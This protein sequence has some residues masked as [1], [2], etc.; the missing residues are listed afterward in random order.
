MALATKIGIGV[1]NAV[2]IHVGSDN[3]QNTAIFRESR[4]YGAGSV[5]ATVAAARTRSSTGID[6][7][8]LAAEAAA[9]INEEVKMSTMGR[10]EYVATGEPLRQAFDAEKYALAG[11]II[12]SEQAWAMVSTVFARK[13]KV[14]PNGNVKID[15]PTGMIRKKKQARAELGPKEWLLNYIPRSAHLFLEAEDETRK[16][17]VSELRRITVL[18]VNI[19]VKR[20][21]I[22][23]MIANANPEGVQLLQDS[24]AKVQEAVMDYEGSVNKFLIDDK[25]STVIVVFGL[26]PISHEN[27]ATRGVL[28]SLAVSSLLQDLG[29]DPAVGVASGSAFCGV[30]GHPGGRRE[31]TVLGDIVNLSARLMQRATSKSLGVLC[32]TE[33]KY[34]AGSQLEFKYLKPISVKGKAKKVD[35]FV[36]FQVPEKRKRGLLAKALKVK[37]DRRRKSLEGDWREQVENFAGQRRDSFSEE[38]IARL[39]FEIQ[40]KSPSALTD[41]AFA[42]SAGRPVS[43]S[44]AEPAFDDEAAASMGFAVVSGNRGTLSMRISTRRPPAPPPPPPRLVTEL[45]NT[46]VSP[47]GE[48]LLARVYRGVV[49]DKASYVIEGSIGIGKS[50]AL[51]LL[52]GILVTEPGLWVLTSQGNPFARGQLAKAFGVIAGL[53]NQAI[54]LAHLEAQYKKSVG[55]S[56]VSS[57][58]RVAPAS[59]HE[60][61]RTQMQAGEDDQGEIAAHDRRAYV[62][63]WLMNVKSKASDFAWLLNEDLGVDFYDKYEPDEEGGSDLEEQRL[64]KSKKTE[65]LM[66]VFRGLTAERQVAVLMDDPMYMD[67]DSWGLILNM[68]RKKSELGAKGGSVVLVS[69]PVDEFV[70]IDPV[71]RSMYEDFARIDH[72]IEERVEPLTAEQVHALTLAYLGVKSIP[73]EIEITTRKCQGN[74][75]FVREM[76]DQMKDTGVI[77]VDVSAGTCDITP[78]GAIRWQRNEGATACARCQ[79]RFSALNRRHHCRC[80]GRIFCADCAPATNK[81]MVVGYSKPQRHCTECFL[82]PVSYKFWAAKQMS[83]VLLDPPV[84]IHCVLGTW[85]DKLTLCQQVLLKVASLWV[86]SVALV[87]W[88]FF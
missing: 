60:L 84:S 11:D 32:D 12:V 20:D 1:G 27:D 44:M 28:A 69:R 48:S 55:G 4:R 56:A 34:L 41:P 63:R 36:P 68:G 3:Q 25:G 52:A 59:Q 87:F 75:L 8:K 53:V 80:C 73:P 38:D 61:Q 79:S 6:G 2:L 9:A 78:L 58:D 49:Q 42:S 33:T 71:A 83:G 86:L 46:S 14:V 64:L 57:D 47:T 66:D 29:T 65:L 21:E 45:T 35:V 13:D 39:K 82:S 23:R 24:F 50:R 88:L 31:Y 81:K 22:A 18:F 70:L 40:T 10:R 72:V 7:A 77:A 67:A 51:T 30:V 54:Q 15:K 85:L 76:L 17:W 37:H 43:Q 74:P 16:D 19:G 5:A 62:L 26:P